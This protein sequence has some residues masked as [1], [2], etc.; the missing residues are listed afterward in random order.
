MSF[1]VE[2]PFYATY[3]FLTSSILAIIIILYI[4]YRIRFNL[5]LRNQEKLK[6]EVSQRTQEIQRM[7]SEI[8][9]QNEELLSQTE[10]IATNNERLE[11]IVQDRTQKLQEQNERLSKYAFMNSHE[12]RGPICRMIGLLNVLKISKSTDHKKLLRLIQ[13]T[14]LELD[15]ITRQINQTL[16]TVDLNEVYESNSIENINVEI[17][18]NKTSQK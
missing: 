18:D 5:I 1:T 12:L 7:N 4:I 10:E 6:K 13:E 15:A 16:S 11:E 17:S 8:Q 9:A 14:G 2:K 3:W